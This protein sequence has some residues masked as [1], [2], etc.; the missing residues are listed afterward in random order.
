MT[1]G[2]TNL[3]LIPI[4]TVFQLQPIFNKLCIYLSVFAVYCF[5]SADNVY[6]CNAGIPLL[7]FHLSLLHETAESFLPL[8]LGCLSV[9]GAFWRCSQLN[10]RWHFHKSPLWE[11]GLLCLHVCPLCIQPPKWPLRPCLLSLP[12]PG[13]W[14]PWTY[15]PTSTLPKRSPGHTHFKCRIPLMIAGMRVCFVV[16]SQGTLT[17]SSRLEGSVDGVS[18]HPH[19]YTALAGGRAASTSQGLGEME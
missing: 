6:I 13:P 3:L 7:H 8:S 4:S 9:C 10:T 18:P 15:P 11:L 2:N 16:M 17:C 12:H 5:Q 19:A 1:E 14:T